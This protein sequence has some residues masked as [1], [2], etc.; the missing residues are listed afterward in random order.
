M[1][2]IRWLFL[3]VRFAICMNQLESDVSPREH[4][5]QSSVVDTLTLAERLL[6]SLKDLVNHTSI[7]LQA[8]ISFNAHHQNFSPL[9]CT[10]FVIDDV[11]F[12]S[13]F[14]HSAHHRTALRKAI[15]HVEAAPHC[16]SS[17]AV[18]APIPLRES[19]SRKLVA[20][21]RRA[22]HLRDGREDEPAPDVAP[23]VAAQGTTRL[24]PRGCSSTLFRRLSFPA[25]A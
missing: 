25:K 19:C 17:C 9:A 3:V 2:D 14:E 16:S 22:R 15:S 4:S 20:E 5:V 7:Q 18:V 12:S 8:N 24:L 23:D 1:L 11:A 6:E 21:Q 10:S 13:D